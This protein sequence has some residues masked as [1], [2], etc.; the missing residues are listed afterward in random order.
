MT[1]R[2]LALIVAND[3]YEHEGLR[4][5]RSPAA[6]AA[7]LADVLGDPT[8]ADFEVAVVHNAPAHEVAARVEDHFTDCKPDD[9]LLLHFSCHGLKNE[10]GELFFAAR[11][12]RPERLGSTAVAADFVQR[13]MRGSRARQMVL[14]L[15]C[16]YGG[17]FAQGV[18]VRASGSANV[19]EA[20]PARPLGGGRGRAVIS[21]SSSMQYSFEGAE[22]ADDHQQPS[23]FT[24]ALVKGLRTGEADRDEDGRVSLSELYDYLFDAVQ[25]QNPNQTPTRDV[26][27]QGEL[28]LARSNRQRVQAGPLPRELAA[29]LGAESMFARLGAVG[30]LRARLRSADLPTAMGALTAL[31]DVA[32]DD[33]RYVADA[34]A[35]AIETAALGA[36]ETALDFG[37]QEVG[38]Q[39]TARTVR[40]VGPPIAMSSTPVP[41]ESWIRV[42]QT[43][44]GLDVFV[45][46]SRVGG[47]R[48]SVTVMGP[49]G[50]LTIEVSA[51]GVTS[52]DEVDEVDEAV[53]AEVPTTGPTAR[54]ET[55]ERVDTAEATGV[56][57]RPTV[58]V[59][60]G[61]RDERPTPARALAYARESPGVVATSAARVAAAG[62]LVAAVLMLLALGQ[63]FRW[64]DT[65]IEVSDNDL[66]PAVVVLSIGSLACAVTLLDRR[67]RVEGEAVL[68]G[69]GACATWLISSLAGRAQMFEG[70]STGWVMVLVAAVI[71]LAAGLLVAWDLARTGLLSVRRASGWRAALVMAAAVVGFVAMVAQTVA[72]AGYGWTGWFV[73]ETL[74]VAVLS[75]AIPGLAVSVRH[76][77]VA[78]WAL[79]AWLAGGAAIGA[80]SIRVL[81]LQDKSADPSVW[82]CVSLVA[83]ALAVVVT[84]GRFADVESEPTPLR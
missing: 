50:T 73:V 16:C 74:W 8:V 25:E 66:L 63:P 21:A 62:A 60:S 5:L 53:A 68:L 15:D 1:G 72:I 42:A 2:R 49:T 20:F 47:Q 9:L 70:Y 41:S 14:F 83:L 40:L 56:S 61:S 29:A 39:S 59:T 51:Q 28:Y 12:T 30:E 7:A 17:A 43:A 45:V 78:L 54:A 37:E 3:D 23:V 84:R 57:E 65:L 13:C 10:A 18:S 67:R 46:P 34:A 27:L 64:D 77:R 79:L 75:A 81:G 4:R 19:L 26:E 48:G 69:L 52:V 58:V 38:R 80:H 32:R 82:F 71:L 36:S 76:G 55:S 11:N 24:A 44:G 6:D 33:I 22:L 31:T 35:E